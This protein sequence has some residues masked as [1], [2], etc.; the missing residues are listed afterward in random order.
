MEEDN[1]VLNWERTADL[2][3]RE[4]LQHAS[5]VHGQGG[6]AAAAAAQERA[7]LVEAMMSQKATIMLLST[8]SV[9]A[10][11]YRGCHRFL[12]RSV[13]MIVCIACRSP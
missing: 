5:A 10:Q 13:T 11:W 7:A 9:Q 4:A 8:V 1:K 2:A 12:H 3:H 6:E